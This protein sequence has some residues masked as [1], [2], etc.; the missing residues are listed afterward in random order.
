MI[1]L[2]DRQDIHEYSKR[3]NYRQSVLIESTANF[4]LYFI[5]LGDSKEEAEFKVTQLSTECA[6][7]LYAYV[8]GNTNSLINCIN[9]SKLPFMDSYAKEKITTDLLNFN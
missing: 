7:Y 9:E 6:S 2:I 1:Y 3:C 5:E 4:I 8:L